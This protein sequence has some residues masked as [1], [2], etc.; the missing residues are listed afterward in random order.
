MAGL[1]THD[2]EVQAAAARLVFIAGF[3]QLADGAQVVLAGAL[4]GAGRTRYA[5]VANVLA[6]YGLGLPLGLWLTYRQQMGPEGLW[7]GLTAGLTVVA[8]ALCRH[9]LRLTKHAILPVVAAP[10]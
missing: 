6:H 4:R 10:R 7:W 5:F 3:F 8:W 2:P 1:M 9:F